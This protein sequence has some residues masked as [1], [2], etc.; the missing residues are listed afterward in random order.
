MR[1]I[2]TFIESHGH[3]QFASYSQEACKHQRGV[4]LPIVI[5]VILVI[6]IR[7]VII[8]ILVIVVIIVIIL[9]IE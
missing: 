9:M 6:V 3:F 1:D 5:I 2:F 4:A 8:T 7:I